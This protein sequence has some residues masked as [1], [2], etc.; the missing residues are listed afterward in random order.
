MPNIKRKILF[1]LMAIGVRYTVWKISR[2]VET[3]AVHQDRRYSFILVRNFPITDQGKITWWEDNKIK[4]KE[5]CIEK[6]LLM[7]ID[8]NPYGRTRYTMGNSNYWQKS[9]GGELT[10]PMF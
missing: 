5:N 9:E 6:K 2:L 1:G 10:A 3:V 7:S 8:K 4:L